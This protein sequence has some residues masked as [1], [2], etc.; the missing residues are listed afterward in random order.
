[1]AEWTVAQAVWTLFWAALV[2]S[3]FIA[4]IMLVLRVFGDIMRNG[5]LNGFGKGAWALLVLAVPFFGV[6]MYLIVHGES[7]SERQLPA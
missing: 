4:W 6:F 7:M 1:M 5:S 3:I 2:W